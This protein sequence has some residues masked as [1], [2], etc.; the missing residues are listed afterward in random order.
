MTERDAEGAFRK[1]CEKEKASSE[2]LRK[3]LE[4]LP[5]VKGKRVLLFS[6]DDPDGITS[7]LIAERLLKRLG[8]AEVGIRMPD[9]Y[10]LETE[11][12][13]AE[14]AKAK[15]DLLV[16]TDKGSLEKI[17]KVV[18]LIPTIVVDHHFTPAP[19]KR[20]VVYNP[21]FHKAGYTSASYLWNILATLLLGPDRPGRDADDFDALVG[22]KADFAI[23]PVRAE[24]PDGSADL[25]A[26]GMARLKEAYPNLFRTVPNVATLFES[27]PRDRTSLLSQ[28]AEVYFAVSG[29]GFQFFY[30]SRDAALAGIHPPTFLLEEIRAVTADVAR[31]KRVATLEA[32][33][34]LLPRKETAERII[35]HFRD[36]W[37]RVPGMLRAAV[38][39]ARAKETT[40]YLFTSDRLWLLPMVG[41]VVLAELV[42]RDKAGAG[43]IFMVNRE[44]N[45]SIHFSLRGTAE[46]VHIGKICGALASRLVEKYGQEKLISGGGHA[47]AGECRTSGAKGV[48]YR[49]ALA[50][51][52]ALLREVE[53]RGGTDHL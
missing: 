5:G 29:G 39:V 21:T 8:A 41:G 51:G 28:I 3:I 10:I 9:R 43:V 6:H 11:E 19:P 32:F 40:F 49:D 18:D 15:W 50:L 35:K 20:A 45:G 44:L 13:E 31:L 26:P 46:A 7:A 42:E 14:L 1:V 4:I 36:D 33:L 23:D 2:G 24:N 53:E 34:A 48:P 47:K 17:D 27:G 52:L 25:V 12:V 38:P 22:L 37:A 30:E 16:C